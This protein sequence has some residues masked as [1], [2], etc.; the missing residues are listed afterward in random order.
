MKPWHPAALKIHDP[1][2]K[3][4]KPWLHLAT[5]KIH[6]PTS[7]K[8]NLETLTP[9]RSMTPPPKIE[10]LTPSNPQDPWPHLQKKMK[11]WHPPALK[12]HDP[13]S[14][15]WNLET[16]TPSSPQDP[17]PHLR[18]FTF[19]R[20]AAGDVRT[21][22]STSDPEYL[23]VWES[24]QL[25][26][27]ETKQWPKTPFDG[28]CIGDLMC[29]Y[30]PLQGFRPVERADWLAPPSVYL[31]TGGCHVVFISGNFNFA[32]TCKTINMRIDMDI[33]DK[34][35]LIDDYVALIFTALCI[36]DYH[37]WFRENRIKK[38][39][40]TKGTTFQIFEHCFKWLLTF[41]SAF[42]FFCSRGDF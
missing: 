33:V 34:W 20:S 14:K 23:A 37:A 5:L 13:T 1:T 28:L 10:T 31:E 11:P 4:R 27:H 30:R 2:S 16:L 22:R 38:N 6:D 36:E 19:R 25:T 18:I 41:Q 39:G 3:K 21:I 42:L 40:S 9:S 12:I 8:W 32:R 15:N 35:W 24:S 7:K 17:W 26:W 29:I